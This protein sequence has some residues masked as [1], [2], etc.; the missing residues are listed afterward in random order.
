MAENTKRKPRTI[1][2][3][4]GFSGVDAVERAF[5]LLDAL[6]SGNS[7]VT[8]KE[9]S[10]RSGLTKPTILRLA[11]SLDKF[12]YMAKDAEGHYHLGPTL[13]RLGS[14]FRQNLDLERIVKPVLEDLVAQTYNAGYSYSSTSG[15]SLNRVLRVRVEGRPAQ[16]S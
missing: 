1:R 3:N 4:D 12:G 16:K 15:A 5:K 2:E 9:L 10:E 6:H 7:A 13:W 11:V 14:F 8:L